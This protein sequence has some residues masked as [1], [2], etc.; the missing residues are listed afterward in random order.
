MIDVS[1]P[2]GISYSGGK[3][4]KWMIY[5]M[6][7]G[8]LPR[9]EHVAV[10]FADTGE[11]HAWTYDDVASVEQD[12]RKN[13]LDFIRCAARESLGD[14]LIKIQVRTATRADTPSLFIEGAGR[15]KHKCTKFFKVAP[16]RR[17]ASSWLKEIGL[18]KRLTKWIGFAKDEQAR[19]TKAVANAVNEPKWERL[20][21]PAIRLGKT[22]QQQADDLTRWGVSV[23]KFSSCTFCPGKTIKRWLDVPASQ[24]ARVVQV[25][26]A[27]REL[28]Q[29]G[30]T[31]GRAYL[32][33][34]CVPVA[35]LI[36]EGIK[37]DELPG[38]ETYCDGGHCFL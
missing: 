1:R 23:P 15:T 31:E 25:D 12:C 35:D 3:S 11:E 17:A 30:L 32:N 4:S 19:A 9:P 18:P 6:L 37:Q 20:D 21:F 29:I 5:A 33:R 8:I 10:F 38:F 26:E 14:H 28:D 22:R 7:N 2:I 27:I 36:R 24:L 16:M 34:F 13:G